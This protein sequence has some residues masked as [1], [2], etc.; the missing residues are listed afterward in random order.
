M[1]ITVKKIKDNK[2]GSMDVE[3]NCCEEGT[4]FLMQQGLIATLVEAIVQEKTGEKFIKTLFRN[5]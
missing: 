2:D 5:R 4:R 3:V 1:E